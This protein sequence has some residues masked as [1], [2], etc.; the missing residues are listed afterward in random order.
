MLNFARYKA[1]H[2]ELYLSNLS[3]HRLYPIYQWLYNAQVYV[4]PLFQ[5]G[6]SYPIVLD[7]YLLKIIWNDHSK[8]DYPVPDLFSGFRAQNLTVPK[9][10]HS[11]TGGVW[12]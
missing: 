11:T 12:Y 2:P 9:E 3:T 10:P 1:K 7:N 8:W 4:P 6:M 5:E